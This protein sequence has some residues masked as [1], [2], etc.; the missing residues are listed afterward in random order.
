M[1]EVTRAPALV[2]CGV[3]AVVKWSCGVIE[4]CGNMSVSQLFSSGKIEEILL[5]MA[6]MGAWLEQSEDTLVFGYVVV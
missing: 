6:L 3:G 4:R 2:D 1:M 5:L